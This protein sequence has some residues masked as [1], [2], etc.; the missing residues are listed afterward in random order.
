VT[1]KSAPVR[2][3]AEA[4]LAA[5]LAV[6]CGEVRE[7]APEPTW[8]SGARL[9]ARLLDGGGGAPIFE[10]F[11]DVELDADCTFYRM[12]D[13]VLRCIPPP[14]SS[15]LLY[16]DAGC[17][18]PSMV[19]PLDD[20]STTTVY[21]FASPSAPL[22]GAGA[23]TAI[24]AL[25]DEVPISEGLFEASDLGGCQPMQ[26]DA[27]STGPAFSLGDEQPLDVYVSANVMHEPVSD[28]LSARKLVADDGAWVITDI[29]DAAS[30]N[31]CTPLPADE[32]RCVPQLAGVI[33][34]RY[35]DA[36]CTEPV[37]SDEAHAFYSRADIDCSWAPKYVLEPRDSC[38]SSF[39]VRAAGEKTTSAFWGNS[40]GS[41]EATGPVAAFTA[42]DPV[43]HA[44]FAK[45]DDVD[46]GTGRLRAKYDGSGRRP[47]VARN[48]FPGT[49]S[50][51]DRDAGERCQRAEACDGSI[52]CEPPEAS[53]LVYGDADCKTKVLRAGACETPAKRVCIARNANASCLEYDYYDTGKQV[54]ADQ[55]YSKLGDRCFASGNVGDDLYFEARPVHGFT[56]PLLTEHVE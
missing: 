41:C 5:V 56:P 4:A 30:G 34:Q 39:V 12:T 22:C 17:A 21:L 10:G 23:L 7:S 15:R 8:E 31:P 14:S 50:F 45:V 1:R 43:S 19:I 40:D 24:R 54:S 35:G 52:R 32:R 38:G 28:A 6:A 9:R 47:I 33:S 53:A 27:S 42:G 2:L 20:P 37:A 44:D 36:E 55:R 11:H 49:F 46:V 29:E 16:S 51:Y 26:T 3:F 25:G 48:A 18:T 13:G